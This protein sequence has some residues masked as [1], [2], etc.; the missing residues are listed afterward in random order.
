MGWGYRRGRGRYVSP[1]AAAR[2]E[3]EE[4]QAARVEA[5]RRRF[6]RLMRLFRRVELTGDRAREAWRAP[7]LRSFEVGTYQGDVVTA[8]VR[9]DARGLY[10]QEAGS[11]GWNFYKLVPKHHVLRVD[12]AL[13]DALRGGR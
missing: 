9:K 8:M 3:R 6:Y 4:R 10:L 5:S 13:R 12:E 2:R 11:M 7:V 1:E